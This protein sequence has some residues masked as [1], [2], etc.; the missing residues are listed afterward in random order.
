MHSHGPWPRLAFA[1]IAC[2]WLA[3]LVACARTPP[4]QALR[5]SMVSLQG[6][7]EARDANS[8]AAA[9]AE[10]FIGPDGLDR[11]GARRIAQLGFMRHRD[12]AVD[13][14]PLDI[15]LRAEHATVRFTAVLRGGSGL[16][17]ESGQ[18]Y[19]VRTA[20][21]RSGDEWLLVNAHWQPRL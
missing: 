20:W 18:V 12:V 9:L 14:G 5:D 6:S 21:R 16:L 17:P 19:D 2:V 10:D 3:A 7:I 8:V 11:A 1:A 13:I 15:E 4:E